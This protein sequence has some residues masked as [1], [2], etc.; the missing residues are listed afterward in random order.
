[1]F[2]LFEN[3]TIKI[4]ITHFSRDNRIRPLVDAIFVFLA[5]TKKTLN[6]KMHF[7]A[8]F[9]YFLIR[10]ENIDS[11]H[12]VRVRVNV[13][14]C[15]LYSKLISCRYFHPNSFLK[16][17]NFLNGQEGIVII[18]GLS[19]YKVAESKPISILFL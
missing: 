7:F 3:Y 9:T 5:L 12:A 1:M 18:L 11:T 2:K 17:E 14:I 15:V 8:H 16:I 4:V 6:C 19:N 10:N 13:N